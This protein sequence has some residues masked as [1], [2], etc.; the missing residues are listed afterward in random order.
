MWYLKKNP[1]VLVAAQGNHKEVEEEVDLDIAPREVVVD[2]EEEGAEAD[3]PAVDTEA[4]REVIGKEAADIPREVGPNPELGYKGFENN[5]VA[6][7]KEVEEVVGEELQ[8]KIRNSRR[9]G[10]HMKPDYYNLD[11]KNIAASL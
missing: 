3:T 4:G 2:T 7:D 11:N 5:L 9:P 10:L 6:A 1:A 8:N